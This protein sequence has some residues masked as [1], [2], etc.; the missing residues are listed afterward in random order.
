MFSINKI[1]TYIESK[2]N[3]YLDN[4]DFY[5]DSFECELVETS[6]MDLQEESDFD[7]YKEALD[8]DCRDESKSNDKNEL[9]S[10]LDW[11]CISPGMAANNLIE[12]PDNYTMW[13]SDF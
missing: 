7:F 5:A 13:V 8:T 10:P 9:I 6:I 12:D 2:W 4:F 3:D 11:G 1:V